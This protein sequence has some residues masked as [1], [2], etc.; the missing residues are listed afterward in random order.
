LWTDHGGVYECDADDHHGNSIPAEWH[1]VA[2]PASAVAVVEAAA[3]ALAA[4]AAAAAALASLD[5]FPDSQCLHVCAFQPT[6]VHLSQYPWA[7]PPPAASKGVQS[8]P[9][10]QPLA[11][12]EP[13]EGA[14]QSATAMAGAQQTEHWLPRGQRQRHRDRRRPV[15]TAQ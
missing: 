1:R 13:L 10:A 11:A 8:V 4:S 2:L 15:A 14:V 9:G 7:A 3:P 6:A 12:E 5:L